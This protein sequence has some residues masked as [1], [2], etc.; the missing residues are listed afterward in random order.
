MRIGID[1]LHLFGAY[2][3]VHYALARTVEAYRRRFP[4]DELVL[5]VPSDFDGPP[6]AAESAQDGDSGEHKPGERMPEETAR[7]GG[8]LDL[9]RTWFKGRWRT[10][11]TVWRNFRLQA[12]AYRDRCEVLHGATYALPSMLSMPAVL[13]VHDLIALTHPQFCTPGSARVQKYTLPRSIKVARR[14]LVPTETVRRDVEMR[15][16]VPADRIDLVPW[17]VDASFRVIEDRAKLDAAREKW[18]LPERFVLFVGTLEPKK[19]IEGLI[20]GFFAAKVHRKLPHALVLAGR[21]GWGMERLERLITELNAREYVFF[22]GYVPEDGLPIV[23][24]LADGLVLPSHVE[25]FGMPVLEA[26]ACGC[27]VITSDAPALREVAGGAARLCSMEGTKALQDFR[28]ALEEVLD[29]KSSVREGLRKQGLERARQFTWQRTA[30]LTR[31]SYARA[32]E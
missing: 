16:K 29:G 8:N 2:S 1:G 20:K 13:T 10:I 4:Q 5:Y 19:N 23:Y 30:E 7:P 9:R 24:N 15:F 22:T 21:M 12:N 32:L 31:A 27:P 18:R 25:G 26:M 28:E 3:G 17:G 14:I 6:R 11:R